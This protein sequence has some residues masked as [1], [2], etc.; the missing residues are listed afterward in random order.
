MLGAGILE[1]QILWKDT[2]DRILSVAA[3]IILA[4][5]LSSLLKVAY[6]NG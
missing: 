2:T 4:S 6:P 1:L 3:D 5:S